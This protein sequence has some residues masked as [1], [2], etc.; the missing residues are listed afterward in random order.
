MVDRPLGLQRVLMKAFKACLAGLAFAA[1][2][3]AQAPQ[4]VTIDNQTVIRLNRDTLYSSAVFDL[5]AG[6]VTVTLPDMGSRVMSMMVLTQDH[7]V[8]AVVH[9][10]GLHQLTRE[11]V[12][13]RHAAV[14]IRTLVD[15]SDP[16]DL[17][18]V[19]AL[20]EGARHAKVPNCIPGM[21]SSSDTVRLYRPR[22][23][24]LDGR[25]KFPVAQPDA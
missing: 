20:Q 6:P 12:G 7:L 21:K 3:V 23:E 5:D 22:A 14:A 9:A 16:A 8:P 25:W 1:A 13:T 15:P 4:P 2:A 18:A 10:S 24:V 11:R 17:R 19:H